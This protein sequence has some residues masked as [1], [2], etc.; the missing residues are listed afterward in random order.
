MATV[1]DNT[2]DIDIVVAVPRDNVMNLPIRCMDLGN[3]GV[4]VANQEPFRVTLTS[5][6]YDNQGVV[7]CTK[8]P[9]SISVNGGQGVTYKDCV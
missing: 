9:F 1:V 3:L 7:K 6:I 2:Q 8:G 5:T 4:A